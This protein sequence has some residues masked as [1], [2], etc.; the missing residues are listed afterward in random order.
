MKYDEDQGV[1]FVVAVEDSSTAHGR[2]LTSRVSP[3]TPSDFTG[4]DTGEVSASDDCVWDGETTVKAI[5]PA[6]ENGSSALRWQ[7]VTEAATTSADINAKENL[8]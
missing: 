8:N 1:T 5:S 6:G 4:M 2:E 7:E 3:C